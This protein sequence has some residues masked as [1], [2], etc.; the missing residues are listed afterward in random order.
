MKMISSCLPMIQERR[1]EIRG[2]AARMARKAGPQGL[3]ALWPCPSQWISTI[4]RVSSAGLRPARHC[5][6]YS[7]REMY[8]DV[9]CYSKRLSGVCEVYR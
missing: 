1:K 9:L 4:Q 6:S 8:C 5:I 3:R 7:A 2:P